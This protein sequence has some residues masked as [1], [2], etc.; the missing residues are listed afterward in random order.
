MARIHHHTPELMQ[1]GNFKLATG[2]EPRPGPAVRLREQLDRLLEWSPADKVALSALIVLLLG[3]AYVVAGY[4]ALAHP[5]AGPYVD[6]RFLHDVVLWVATRVFIPVWLGMLVAALVLRRRPTAVRVLIY[7]MGGFYAL[8]VGLCAYFFGS[9]TSVY[10]GL[11]I[12][13]GAGW[14]MLLFDKG[15]VLLGV[16]SFLVLISATTLA[17]QLGW[18]P[19]A[20]I[21]VEAPFHGQRLGTAWLLVV[22]SVDLLLLL[23]V[24]GLL[25]HAIDRWR[26]HAVRLAHTSE[27][28][29]RANEIISRYVASQLVK[30][31]FAGNYDAL[32]RHDRRRLTLFFSDIQEFST[33]ADEIEPEDLSALLNEYLSEMSAIGERY[34]A[35]IDKFVGDAIMIFFGAP[36]ATDDRDHALRAVRMAIEMQARLGQMRERW[37]RAGFA[38]TFQIRVGINTG[39]ATI[40]TFGS[41]GRVDYTAIG[42]QVNLAARLQASCEPGKILISQATWLLVD[43][44]VLCVPKGDLH[45]KGFHRP[46]SVY[47]VVGVPEQ[48]HEVGSR[49]E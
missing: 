40:G 18:L 31:I 29:G 1:P 37:H 39:H 7:L 14:G 21:L 25:Y 27:Q 5:E 24:L 2:R 45:V 34:G 32:E 13:G 42:R 43:D 41:K 47:E 16:A 23:V 22:G 12:L 26:D 33:I 38:R 30:Q 11:V 44:E 19:Y 35:T 9:H 6:R 3:A 17:E 10:T 49:P 15:P 48:S 4:Y 28:L 46:V 36:V 8:W 20:P